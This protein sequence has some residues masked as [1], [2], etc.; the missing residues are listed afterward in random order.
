MIYFKYWDFDHVDV[1]H[2]MSDFIFV[3]KSVGVYTT[4]VKLAFYIDVFEQE[5]QVDICMSKIDNEIYDIYAYDKYCSTLVYTIGRSIHKDQVLAIT[6]DFVKS[7]LSNSNIRF[8][9]SIAEIRKFCFVQNSR[10]FYLLSK[11]YNVSG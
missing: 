6:Y 7:K 8:F 9:K 1:S 2:E 4:T 3:E 11:K 10:F 5:E